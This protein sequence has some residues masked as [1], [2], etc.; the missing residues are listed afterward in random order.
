MKK[1]FNNASDVE[2]FIIREYTQWCRSTAP[3]N[4]K[5]KMVEMYRRR[6]IELEIEHLLFG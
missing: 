3:L 2:K 5:I 1:A 6:A 4:Y